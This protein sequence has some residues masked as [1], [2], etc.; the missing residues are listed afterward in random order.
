[1]PFK[2]AKDR[3]A[4]WKKY[5]KRRKE[6]PQARQQRNI[7]QA[8]FQRTPKG[9]SVHL[10]SRYGITFDYKA[11]MHDKQ[12]GLCGLCGKPLPSVSQSHYDHNHETGKE[13]ELLHREC[14]FLVGIFEKYEITPAQVNSYVQKHKI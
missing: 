12:K 14:N 11:S 9:K 1:M 6:P 4:W 13:R 2:H 8:K 5:R 10:K 3:R 7:A